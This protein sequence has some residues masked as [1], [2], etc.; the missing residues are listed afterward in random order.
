[1]QANLKNIYLETL[2]AVAPISLVQNALSQWDLPASVDVLALGKAASP[3]MVGAKKVLGNRLRRG[4]VLTKYAHILPDDLPFLGDEIALR[5]AGHPVPDLSGYQATEDLIQWLGQSG[6]ENLLVLCSGGASSLLVSPSPPLSLED[7]QTIN[8]ALLRSGFPIET[9]NILRKHLSRVKGGQLGAYCEHNYRSLRQLLMVDICAP[10]LKEEEILSLVG[11]GPFMADP[12]TLGEAEELLKKLRAAL[13]V[14]IFDRASLALRETPKQSRCLNQ[15]LASHHS[16]REEAERLAGPAH[17][18]HSLWEPVV[19]GEVSQ[20][21]ESMGRCALRLKE[22]QKCGVLVASGEPTVLI[23][24]S[25]SGRGG[26]CQELALRFAK[27][28]SG[29]VGVALL[30]GSSDGTDGPTEEAGALVDGDTWHEICRQVG[31][32]SAEAMLDSHDSGTALSL[33]AGSLLFTGPT[34]QNLNDLYLLKVGESDC[35]F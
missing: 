29:Q 32:K 14:D 16:L 2:S 10:Q 3:M 15:I 5:E 23:E 30:A 11:S 13:S 21:A 35:G 18:E 22:E 6:A 31:E 8:G 25:R 33:V 26:R 9:L 4:F 1:M 19:L 34:G 24:G 7:L 27:T 17:L 28:V 12:S 20:L